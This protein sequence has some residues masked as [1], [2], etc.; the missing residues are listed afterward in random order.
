MSFILIQAQ[1]TTINTHTSFDTYTQN[2]IRLCGDP[3]MKVRPTLFN[4]GSIINI[5]FP[6]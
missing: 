5:F 1:S 4:N 2:W 6:T 3:L